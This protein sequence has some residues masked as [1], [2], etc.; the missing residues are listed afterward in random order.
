MGML[1]FLEE[2][3]E[4]FHGF[5]LALNSFSLLGQLLQSVS[6]SLNLFLFLPDALQTKINGRFIEELWEN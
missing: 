3:L 6:P 1:T 5:D 4:F 2:G